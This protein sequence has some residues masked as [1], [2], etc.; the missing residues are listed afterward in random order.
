MITIPE[1]ISFQWDEGNKDKNF[2][3]HDVANT[4]AEE[5]FLDP[6]RLI[7]KDVF[8]SEDEKRYMLIGETKKSRLLFIAFTIRDNQV[9]VIS[10][11][12]MKTKH[13]S[14]YYKKRK[15][16]YEKAA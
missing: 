16:R 10:A 14:I 11:R 2:Q 5:A 15:D 7:S 12:D 4:E 3:K 13:K 9:R 1:P 6:Y 8:H